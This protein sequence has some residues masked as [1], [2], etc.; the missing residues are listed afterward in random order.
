MFVW[1][2]STGQHSSPSARHSVLLSVWPQ[3]SQGRAAGET[4]SPSGCCCPG[5]RS[6][7]PSWGRHCWPLRTPWVWAA[8]C[9]PCTARTP[10]LGLPAPPWSRSSRSCWVSSGS[11]S[12]LPTR[13][14]E[15]L[16]RWSGRHS[17]RCP[18]S[19]Q[20]LHHLHHHPPLS[21]VSSSV[22]RRHL[23]HQYRE[24]SCWLFPAAWDCLRRSSLCW[25]LGW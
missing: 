9:P 4:S 23:L 11:V 24:S 12:S 16:S 6:P 15:W 18:H 19:T 5:Q 20:Q 17:P 8:G 10:W 25:S 22:W 7:T 14:T 1:M 3:V 2:E 21:R 13:G